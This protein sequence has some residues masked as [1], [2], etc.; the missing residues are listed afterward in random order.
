MQG[1]VYSFIYNIMKERAK[2]EPCY[3]AMSQSRLCSASSAD[4]RLCVYVFLSV[5]VSVCLSV[6]VLF[7]SLS[8]NTCP[9]T[10]SSN[11][12]RWNS[13]SMDLGCEDNMGIH[14]FCQ[15]VSDFVY[16]RCI[17]RKYSVLFTA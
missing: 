1:Q 4:C 2:K 5:Y 10:T 7:V 9:S 13:V 8:L 12:L 16:L 14:L 15:C 11:T 3:C 6:S 17:F